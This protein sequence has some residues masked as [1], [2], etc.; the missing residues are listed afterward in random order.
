MKTAHLVVIA[1]G[2]GTRFWPRSTRKHPKQ[3]L[4]FGS[5]HS[6]LQT[7]LSRFTE[8][9]DTERTWILTTQELEI[10]LRGDLASYPQVQILSEPHGRN[11]A[12]CIYW[13]ARKLSALD[14]DALM[15]IVPSD[16]YVGDLGVFRATI[17]HAL[18]WAS[19]HDGLVTLGI[20][21]TRPETGYGYLRIHPGSLGGAPP[22]RVEQFVEKP[23]L[24]RAR[25][26][27]ATNQFLWNGGIFIWRASAILR[28]FDQIAPEFREVWT[29]YAGD[30]ALCYPHLPSISI[31][32]AILERSDQVVAFP[33]YCGWDDL[34]SWTSLEAL[35]GP[36]HLESGSN[37]LAGGSLEALDSHGN[38]V[39]APD[40]LVSLLGVKDLIVVQH[41]SSLLVADKARAQDVKLLV[42]QIRQRQPDRV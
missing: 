24:E 4:R 26:Y 29:T 9:I 41:G 10:A 38:I 36:L 6:L 13:A 34:G 14:P 25:D 33:L 32:Y 40:I 1:G 39:D 19:E 27:V 7:T 22:Y 20:H 21:P 2:T 37:V 15:V 31:D 23:S 30:P 3:L 28:A 16:Q 35:A 17:Q 12:P 11:T 42:E 5:P 8:L 18:S